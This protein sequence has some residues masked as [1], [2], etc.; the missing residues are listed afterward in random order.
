MAFGSG[1]VRPS[2]TGRPQLERLYELRR[3]HYSVSIFNQIALLYPVGY[4][5]AYKTGSSRGQVRGSYGH[6]HDR[7]GIAKNLTP[8]FK[9]ERRMRLAA[10]APISIC[11][12]SHVTVPCS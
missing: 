3:T 2:A 9:S 12:P 11:T 8:S 7:I 5:W 6:E 4:R 1:A 10:A